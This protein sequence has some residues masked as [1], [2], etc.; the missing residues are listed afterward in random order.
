MIKVQY[1]LFSNT[2]GGCLK[3]GSTKFCVSIVFSL[4]LNKQL[5]LK[6][7]CRGNKWKTLKSQIIEAWIL[8]CQLRER[9]SKV[10]EAC[11][12]IETARIRAS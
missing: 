11:G 5:P 9:A 3:H 10:N 7:F 8:V 6:K 12:D 2:V 1:I 4:S